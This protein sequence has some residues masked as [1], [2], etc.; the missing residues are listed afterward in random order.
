MMQ[1]RIVD[2]DEEHFV[3]FFDGPARIEVSRIGD[4]HIL[5]H[6]YQGLTLDLTQEPSVVFDG[7]EADSMEDMDA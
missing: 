2:R 3:V 1:L 7:T 5:M 6:A 4:G